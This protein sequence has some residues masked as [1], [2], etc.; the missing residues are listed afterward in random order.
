[1]RIDKEDV[2]LLDVLINASLSSNMA[3]VI[4]LPPV[5]P[6]RLIDDNIDVKKSHYRRLFVI[7]ND[8]EYGEMVEG[9]MLLGIN[10]IPEVTRRF[11]E[12]GGFA[13]LYRK[14]G[15]EELLQKA[16]ED[17][18]LSESVLV[19]WHKKTYWWTFVLAIIGAVFGIIS[20]LMQFSSIWCP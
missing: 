4:D 16:S 10:E 13:E 5:G 6:D 2:E 18:L 19:G 7:I 14:Q 20:L 11:K 8:L 9:S 15:H 3:S 17:K 1:M 12:S